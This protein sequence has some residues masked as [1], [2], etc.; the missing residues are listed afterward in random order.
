MQPL[1]IS[2]WSGLL[3]RPRCWCAWRI[4]SIDSSLAES[5]NAQVF[6]T[7]TSASS[8][9]DVISIPRCKTL[10]SMISASTRFL[11]Q[12]RLIMPTFGFQATRFPFVFI[13]VFDVRRWTLGVFLGPFQLPSV[14]RHVCVIFF[15]SFAVFRDCNGLTIENPN[16]DVFTPKFNRAISRR[17]PMFE[18]GL[19]VLIAYGHSHVG[20]FKWENRDPILVSCFCGRWIC[21]LL[22]FGQVLS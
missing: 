14:H 8:G 21:H 16:R 3:V 7:R 13:S 19:A 10:P 11:A 6:T 4:A 2:F 22:C 17:H 1:T 20:S 9:R 5:I 18:R 12:P 15:Q